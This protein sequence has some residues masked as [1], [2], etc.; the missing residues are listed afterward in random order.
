MWNFRFSI[1]SEMNHR[2][3]F[4]KVQTKDYAYSVGDFFPGERLLI[5]N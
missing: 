1:P 4:W 2:L 3:S 5:N